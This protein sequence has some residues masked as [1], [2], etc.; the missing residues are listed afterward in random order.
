MGPWLRA[1]Y[2][3][4]S[5]AFTGERRRS[6]RRREGTCGRAQE[7]GAAAAQTMQRAR[8]ADD[9]EDD[10][11]DGGDLGISWAAP[12]APMQQQ[13]QQEKERGSAKEQQQP[14]QQQKQQQVLR[15][16]GGRLELVAVE[17]AADVAVAQGPAAAGKP[18]PA[19]ARKKLGKRRRRAELLHRLDLLCR[20]AD[21]LNLSAVCDAEGVWAEARKLCPVPFQRIEQSKRLQLLEGW[22][23]DVFAVS[24]VPAAVPVARSA[25]D[26][27]RVF[28][29]K[30]GGSVALTQAFVAI[31]RSVGVPARLVAGMDPRPRTLVQGKGPA[32]KRAKVA[33]A[34]NPDGASGEDAAL[35]QYWAE[36]LVIPLDEARGAPTRSAHVSLLSDSDDEVALAELRETPQPSQPSQPSQQQQQPP[37]TPPHWLSVE[38]F[39]RPHAVGRPSKRD[40]GL[41]YVV[42]VGPGGGAVDVTARYAERWTKVSK[43]RHKEGDGW[44]LLTLMSL[45]N[46]AAAWIQGSSSSGVLA[47]GASHAE[48]LS[49]VQRRH[50]SLALSEPLAALE[51][52]ELDRCRAAESMPTSVE[53]FKRHERYTLARGVGRYRCLGPGASRVSIFKGE[54][55]F[56]AEDVRD[57]LSELQWRKRLRSVRSAELDRAAKLVEP[58]R[59][60]KAALTLAHHTRKQLEEAAD[61]LAAKS[62]RPAGKSGKP[63]GSEQLLRHGGA[64]ADEE[65]EDEVMENQLQPPGTTQA[66]PD[67]RV[68][69]YGEWQTEAWEPPAVGP[70]GKVPKSEFGNVEL[71]TERHLPRGAVHLREPD[72]AAAARELKVD[73]APALVGFERRDG[74]QVPKLDGVVVAADKAELVREA[75]I[76]LAQQRAEK[77]AQKR[78]A[79]VLARWAALF[80]G[81]LVRD[82]LQGKYKGGAAEGAASATGDAPVQLRGAGGCEHAFAAT[83]RVV[84][85]GTEHRCS[86][87]GMRKVVEEL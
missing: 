39:K 44:W 86:K 81:V 41:P 17:T 50:F 67:V 34:L 54:D 55:V 37:P 38:L 56:L 7:A 66:A 87:C 15:T 20:L 84:G 78:E 32:G 19:R 13:T 75:A 9:S 46:G 40:P 74:H 65:L 72:A 47:R 83:G 30:R 77:Q 52:V 8:G 16:V 58:A 42:G 62:A 25:S 1:G 35:V 36:V 64:D 3:A 70:D 82:R 27:L 71:W 49:A 22:F 53:G 23:T 57:C 69:L 61:K 63:R 18:D 12:A 80:K 48:R 45:R 51:A 85:D 5:A 11:D 43:L 21:A 33:A 31:C 60:S 14:Q 26:L 68:R 24:P 79:R 6:W 73:F 28:A 4:V 76:A 59:G 29:D 10:S 2:V